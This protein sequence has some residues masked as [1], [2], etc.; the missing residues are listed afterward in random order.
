MKLNKPQRTLNKISLQHL[1]LKTASLL[2][3]V[4]VKKRVLV[5]HLHKLW[6]NWSGHRGSIVVSISACQ[7]KTRVQVPAGGAA[8]CYE[9]NIFSPKINGWND[10]FFS[11]VNWILKMNHCC[12]WA[13]KFW[14]CS[15]PQKSSCFRS[16]GQLTAKDI[17]LRNSN[18]VDCSEGFVL[19][20]A[21][22]RRLARLSLAEPGS[23]GDLG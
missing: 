6:L 16:L 5:G 12:D 19:Y 22:P 18:P 2:K 23:S 4:N 10:K 14:S 15:S 9:V 3:W 21:F 13:K 1:G 20:L 7:R 17:R 8:A 11:A